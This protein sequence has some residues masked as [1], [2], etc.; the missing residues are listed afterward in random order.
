MVSHPQ[1]PSEFDPPAAR[2]RWKHSLDFRSAD[3]EDCRRFVVI[4]GGQSAVE[5]LERWLQRRRAGD[6]AWISLRSPLKA[7]PHRVLGVDVHYLIWPFEFLDA[8]WLGF[9]PIRFRDPMIGFTTSRALRRGAIDRL[10]FVRSYEP[11]A[12]ITADGQRVEPDLVVFATGFRYVLDHVAHLL[13]HDRRGWPRVR[14]CESV[15]TPGLY[16]L[17]LRYCRSLAS[18]YLRG[19]ARDAR[20]VAARIAGG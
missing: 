19:I 18:A 16:V 20:A 13:D 17:G 5:L 14:G 2:Y 4:G 3:L 11:D 9:D 15:R 7:V 1:L 10:G 6:R 12:L 8:R